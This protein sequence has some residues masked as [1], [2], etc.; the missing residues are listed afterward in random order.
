MVHQSASLVLPE[1]L[2][3]A[4]EAL[5]LS[6]QDAASQLQVPVDELAAWENGTAEPPIERLWDLS[7]L[8]RRDLDYFL[9]RHQA[10]PA[11]L[12]FRVTHRRHFEDLSLQTRQAI[13]AF[14]DLC[15]SAREIEA[16]LDLP[17]PPPIPVARGVSGEELAETER[18]R[19]QID[20]KPVRDVR[21]LVEEQ[22]VLCFHLSVP[23]Q[24]FSGLSWHHR[25]YGPCILVNAGDNPG[26]RAF[27]TAHEYGHLLRRDG[28]S[29][30]DLQLDTRV[31]RE[32]NRFATCFLMPG[33]DIVQTF[34]RRGLAG[35]TPSLEQIDALAARYRVSREALTLR[36]EELGLIP[37]DA[38]GLG[39]PP[40]YYGRTRPKWRRRVGETF[41]SR[42]LESHN[43]GRVSIGKLARYLGVDIRQ[44]MQLVERERAE[45][46]PDEAL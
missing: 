7:E 21:R 8:Y 37:K 10:V 19:L 22:R 38:I 12:N 45:R 32:A 3:Q 27:T 11:A 14:D 40:R 46:E 43:S 16:T 30:C 44:A 5:A 2:R 17:D 9:L 15:R 20:D 41:T 39:A 18:L 34:N 29:L 1:Q 13:A 4:R 33:S 42:A 24:E 31:E 36:L 26:R 28:D 25:E 23:G 6:Q 35:S